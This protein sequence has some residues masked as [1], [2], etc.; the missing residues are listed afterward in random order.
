MHKQLLAFDDADLDLSTVRKVE[1]LQ[2]WTSPASPSPDRIST[3]LSRVAARS[4]SKTVRASMYRPRHFQGRSDN[5]VLQGSTTFSTG[6]AQPFAST[7]E[8]QTRHHIELIPNKSNLGLLALFEHRADLAMIST[9]LEREVEI[10]RKSDPSFRSRNWRRL[11]SPGRA[12]RWLFI[13][14][15]RFE[16][17]GLKET[18]RL[19]GPVQSSMSSVARA[20]AVATAG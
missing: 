15:T 12:P 9:T 10:L 18:H 4:P 16:T 8:A 1:E 14:T 13:R 11:K 6:L 7:V 17:R 3:A 19:L 20:V 5:L 2:R